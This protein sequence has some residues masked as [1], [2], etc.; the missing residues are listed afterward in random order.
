[1]DMSMTNK[2]HI[3]FF[4]RYDDEKDVHYIWENMK[5]LERNIQIK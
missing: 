3:K 2:M 1:M 4:V 5:L